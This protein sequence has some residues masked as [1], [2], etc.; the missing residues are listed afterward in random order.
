MRVAVIV[1]PEDLEVPRELKVA[2]VYRSLVTVCSQAIPDWNPLSL[3][4]ILTNDPAVRLLNRKYRKID[5]TTDV[6]SFRYDSDEGEI[7]ISVPQASRQA[8]RYRVSLINEIK[9]LVIHGVLH[10]QGYDHVR[11]TERAGMRALESRI[12]RTATKKGVW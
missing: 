3:S 9:R 12:S 7:I 6:L 10:V 4:F 11:P 2:R 5:R 8:R 1:E